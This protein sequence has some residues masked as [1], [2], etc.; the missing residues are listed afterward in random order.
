M[1]YEPDRVVQ[2][3]AQRT[4]ANLDA[5]RRLRAE[6]QPVYEVT[7]LMNS[8][9]GL[10]VFPKEKFFEVLPNMP[11]NQLKRE[12]WPV[13]VISGP[14]RQARNLKQLIRFLRNA[15]AHFNIEFLP[16]PGHPEDLPPEITGLR[17]WNTY[18]G[19]KTWEATLSLE[20]LQG[21]TERFLAL[22]I[23]INSRTP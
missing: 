5:I 7:Q 18:E 21:I 23:Q 10:L 2:D 12:G 22:V 13:P 6:G 14:Y 11:L 8:L 17:V 3:F 4:Q 19:A 16:A 15:V 9:L 20:D 1:I